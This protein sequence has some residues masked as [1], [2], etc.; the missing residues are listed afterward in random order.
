MQRRNPD[1]SDLYTWGET[2]RVK[3]IRIKLADPLILSWEE[4]N[5]LK[6]H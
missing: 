5:L 3:F 2:G 6:K 4:L 1:D